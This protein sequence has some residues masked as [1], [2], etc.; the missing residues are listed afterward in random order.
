MRICAIVL[1]EIFLAKKIP[2][3]GVNKINAFLLFM[4][5]A[6]ITSTTIN[7]HPPM[8]FT[9]STVMLK[10]SF[11]KYSKGEPVIL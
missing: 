5:E 11:V 7:S 6:K 1:T 8:S 10:N 4:C 2:Q 9:K 3:P